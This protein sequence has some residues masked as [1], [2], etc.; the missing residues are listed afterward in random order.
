VIGRTHVCRLNADAMNEAYQ[1]LGGY[2]K[3]WQGRLDAL[4]KVLAQTTG[5]RRGGSKQK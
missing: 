1:W 4:E 5:G 2:E 3:F